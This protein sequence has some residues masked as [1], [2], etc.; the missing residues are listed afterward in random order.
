MEASRWDGAGSALAP[1]DYAAAARE[2]ASRALRRLSAD[3]RA[4]LRAA[5]AEAR[6]ADDNHVGTEHLVLGILARPRSIGARALVRA[7]IKR[8]VFVAQR[9]EEPGPSPPGRIPYTPRA[10]RSIAVAGELAEARGV[11]GVTTADLLLGVIYES[12][13]WQS[14]GRAGPHHLAAA[15]DAVGSSLSELRQVLA[16]LAHPSN[17]P[18]AA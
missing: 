7:G 15:A 9:Y 6:A 17:R 18:S 12:E 10:N 16:Q 3:A 14:S 2:G 1:P 5:Q 4:T 8:E 13:E 11:D